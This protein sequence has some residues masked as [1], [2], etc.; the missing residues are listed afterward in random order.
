MNQ[1]TFAFA[2]KLKPGQLELFSESYYD[3][4][5]KRLCYAMKLSNG[6]NRWCPNN[7][8]SIK[9]CVRL[10]GVNHETVF[11]HWDDFVCQL[12][13]KSESQAE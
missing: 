4:R 13:S 8:D 3:N 2:D 6:I 9:E 12:Q 5:V 11:K 10:F 1:L 7:L